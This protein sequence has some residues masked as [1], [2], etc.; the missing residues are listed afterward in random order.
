VR[1]PVNAAIKTMSKSRLGAKNRW[2]EEAFNPDLSV[3][4]KRR[5]AQRYR[6]SLIF[7]GRMIFL[8]VP[9]AIQVKILVSVLTKDL[10]VASFTASDN[11][12]GYRT[13]PVNK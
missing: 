1:G 9:S 4:N 12:P 5:S 11:Q 2:N 13:S 6:L 3:S 8:P 7:R 10:S